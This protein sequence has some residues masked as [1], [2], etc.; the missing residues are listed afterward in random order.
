MK[1]NR[2][3][4]LPALFA[5]LGSEAPGNDDY[6]N[7]IRQVQTVSNA[8]WQVYVDP[9]GE[10]LS[11][12]S[13][14]PGGARFELWTVKNT[15]LQD[16]LLDHKYVGTYVPRAVLTIRS[17]DPYQV[18]PRTRADRPFFVDVDIQGLIIGDPSAPVAAQSVDLTHHVQSYG[19]TNG[20]NIDRSQAQLFAEGSITENGVQTF[21]YALTSVPGADRAKVRGEERFTVM[22]LPD[23]QAP[24]SQLAGGFIQIWPVADAQITGLNDGDFIR[25]KM[26]PFEIHLNDLYPD[27]ETWAQVY[28]GSPS[29]GT[30]GTIVP[31]SAVVVSDSVPQ[32][33]VLRILDWDAALDDD[34]T[35]TLEVLHE[36]PFGLERLDYVTFGIDRTL[37]VHGS[38]TTIE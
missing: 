5:A 10:Q 30:A 1:T 25:F 20:I 2:I 13:V 11:P 32:D 33:R 22:S 17:E 28:P 38:V 15:P 9:S 4:L 21:S 14:D 23:Y 3:F 37:E 29:L 36:T 8:E 18:I 35:W 27:S 26:P 16:Y 7:F 6:T 12:L 31:G 24:A 34:G 19:D